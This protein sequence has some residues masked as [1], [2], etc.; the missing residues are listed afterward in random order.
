MGGLIGHYIL[1]QWGAGLILGTSLLKSPP[2][3][4]ILCPKLDPGL[5]KEPIT[6]PENVRIA[7][8]YDIQRPASI[9]KMI[10]FLK[11]WDGDCILFSMNSTSFG[12]TSL[13]NLSGLALPFLTKFVL[14]KRVIVVYHSSVLTS[15]YLKL[16][17]HSLPDRVRASA[18]SVIEGLLFR[19]LPT[20]VLLKYYKKRIDSV[21]TRSNVRV[22]ENEFLEAIPTI[23]LNRMQSDLTPSSQSKDVI[24][25]PSLLLHGY[26]GPQKDL[27]GVLG[28]LRRLREEGFGFHLTISGSINPH[29]PEYTATFNA[30]I[31]SNASVVSTLRLSIPEDQ[32][33]SLM[34]ESDLLIL[35]YNA[36]GGQSGVMEIGSCFDLPILVSDFPEYREKAAQKPTVTV[37]PDGMMEA[38]LRQFLKDF[39]P[40]LPRQVKIQEKLDRVRTY[41]QTL[42]DE[43]GTLE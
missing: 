4:V 21:I 42:V 16:G 27:N 5:A 40:H 24:R 7:A 1:S 32:I 28:I 20:Y 25:V 36:S 2:E 34:L 39:Q 10:L 22:F 9:L 38:A 35:P 29:F 30:I 41:V 14:R 23:W 3:V 6:Y 37:Y 33:V 15:D 11:D 8:T 43:A 31:K 26:W 19:Y 12:S 13:S 17:Y 18:L